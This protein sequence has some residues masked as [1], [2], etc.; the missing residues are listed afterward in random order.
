M[1]EAVA[2]QYRK[3]MKGGFKNAGSLEN[4]TMFIDAKAEGISICGQ[5]RSDYMN[6]YIKTRDDVITD[7]KY[8]CSC[9]P[10]ANVVVEALCDLARG[11][12]LEKA[13]LLT[14]DQLYEIIGC[15]EGS[16][17]RKVWAAI[18]LINIVI[19]R[20]ELAKVESSLA[21]TDNVIASNQ[22]A[23]TAAL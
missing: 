13:R 4:P 19:K 20:Y 16:V 21:K 11:L 12:T 8:L 1:H 2:Q 22:A 15:Q 17:P 7:I 23:G 9:D 18:E 10:T 14:K 6:I 5:G 3:L